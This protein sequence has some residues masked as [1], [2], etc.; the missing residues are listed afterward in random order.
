MATATDRERQEAREAEQLAVGPL[1]ARAKLLF[2]RKQWDEAISVCTD[3]LRK[4]PASVT[5]HSLLG[6]IY[7]AQGRIDDAI[8]WYAMALER[9]P[10]SAS[11]RTKLERLQQTHMARRAAE[12]RRVAALKPAPPPPPRG[13]GATEKTIEKTIE[14]FDRLFPPG[15]SESIARLIFT[16]CG[17][18]AALLLIGTVVVYV[19]FTRDRANP[20]PGPTTPAYPQPNAPV[21]VE[22]P[23][24]DVVT[25]PDPPP[26]R[27]APAP[28]PASTPPPVLPLTAASPSA[29]D[30]A[31][32]EAILR[33]MGG[34]AVNV[35]SVARRDA[36]SAGVEIEIPSAPAE[37]VEKTRE[38]VI[39][40]A[41][42]A[43]RAS[44]R[45]DVGLQRVIIQVALGVPAQET[46]APLPAFRGEIPLAG[47][48]DLDPASA[49]PASLLVR[50]SS[51]EWGPSLIPGA[52]GMNATTLALPAGPANSSPA[53]AAPSPAAGS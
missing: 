19:V 4:Y 7:E 50:F 23:A 43:A 42:Q 17:V 24:S 30:G 41:V 37:G 11:D 2:M 36:G 34:A 52:G 21:V 16:V 44:L 39:R 26:A 9:D 8:Q 20:L 31:L 40:A 45:A 49:D 6:D 12:A 32:R 14:W 29:V 1:L 47:V 3:A 27:V 10:G 46:A 48:R 33:G 22:P 28:V 25:V 53:P 5:A 18:I 38:R 13:R 15:H 35:V 51:M